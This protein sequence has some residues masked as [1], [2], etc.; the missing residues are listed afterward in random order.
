MVKLIE[1]NHN[2]YIDG[3]VQEFLDDVQLFSSGRVLT[4]QPE[5][6]LRLKGW[7]EAKHCTLPGKGEF[8]NSLNRLKVEKILS[9]DKHAW[10]VMEMLPEKIGGTENPPISKTSATGT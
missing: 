4:P 1:M 3:I 2:E 7:C 8:N 9:K 6:Y 10:L 5:V